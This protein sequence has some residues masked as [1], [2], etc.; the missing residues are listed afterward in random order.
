MDYKRKR[1][2]LKK[3][4]I[5][6]LTREETE[7]LAKLS[8]ESFFTT[9]H[10]LARTDIIAALVDA[11]MAMKITANDIR[12]KEDL[13][14]R[15]LSLSMQ[16]DKRKYPRL[17]KDLKINLREMESIERHKEYAT[18][19]IS[20]GGF[21]V[22]SDIHNKHLEPGMIIETVIKDPDEE[23]RPLR[24]IGRVAWVRERENKEG[25]EAGIRLTYMKEEDRMRFKKYLF[26]EISAKDRRKQ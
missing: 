2:E 16:T 10:K 20:L 18:S 23:T 15:I 12:N 22:K 5:A 25:Y 7:F 4:I 14:R 26:Q 9:G 6:F 21:R 19:D 17:K 8:M 3:R 13:V 1:K 11:V 24:A